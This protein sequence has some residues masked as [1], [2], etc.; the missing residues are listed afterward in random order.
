MF[1][2]IPPRL[3]ASNFSLIP[4][5]GKIAPRRV[6]SPVMEILGSMGMPKNE[7]TKAVTIAVI[8]QKK[9]FLKKRNKRFET[10]HSQHLVH[11]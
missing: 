7:D 9:Y 5:T 10:Y 1:Y 8:E 3:A 2:L 6:T 11:L 4:P